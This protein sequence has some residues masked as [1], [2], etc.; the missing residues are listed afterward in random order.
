M[1]F[2][3]ES[4]FCARIYHHITHLSVQSLNL[5]DWTLSGSFGFFPDSKCTIY[6]KKIAA[7]LSELA[8]VTPWKKPTGLREMYESL[9]KFL[10]NCEVRVLTDSVGRTL[11][12]NSSA[13]RRPFR[14]RFCRQFRITCISRSAEFRGKLWGSDFWWLEGLQSGALWRPQNAE[15]TVSILTWFR[16]GIGVVTAS[17]CGIHCFDSYLIPFRNRAVIMRRPFLWLH[18]DLRGGIFGRRLFGAF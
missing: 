16:S 8:C 4:F 7:N 5:T 3:E 2:G 12:L 9:P 15:F 17:K 14:V 13:V 11:G 10:R 18:G 6:H 1:C